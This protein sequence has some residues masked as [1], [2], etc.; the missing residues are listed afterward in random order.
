M[1]IKCGDLLQIKSD[2]PDGSTCLY[3][4]VGPGKRSVI[5]SNVS[6]TREY[7][8][9][10]LNDS[11]TTYEEY[12]QW[13]DKRCIMYHYPIRNAN[14]FHSAWISMGFQPIINGTTCVRFEKLMIDDLNNNTDSSSSFD[15]V[16]SLSSNSEDEDDEDIRSIDSFSSVEYCSSNSSLGT[17]SSFIVEDSTINEIISDQCECETCTETRDAVDAFDNRWFPQQDT[18]EHRIKSFVEQLEEKYAQ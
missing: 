6:I 18:S 5:E 13:I 12:P 15:C 11:Q 14:D 17:T 1:K 10:L 16:S 4:E 7:E 2:N 8:V 3:G 9:F